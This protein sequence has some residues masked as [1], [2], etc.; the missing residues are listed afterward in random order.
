MYYPKT[1]FAFEVIAPIAVQNY[2]SAVIGIRIR[3]DAADA[4]FVNLPFA[5]LTNHNIT[6][7]L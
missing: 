1:L 2:K 7:H 4:L 3:A 5:V 6:A